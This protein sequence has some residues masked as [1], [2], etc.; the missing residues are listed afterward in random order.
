M[1]LIRHKQ[2]WLRE[3]FKRAYKQGRFID[4]QKLIAEFCLE[5]AAPRRNGVEILGMFL[6]SGIVKMV[7]KTEME[8]KR[9]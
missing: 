7:N 4:K 5:F 9:V 2:E 1:A 6:T 3:V 8:V